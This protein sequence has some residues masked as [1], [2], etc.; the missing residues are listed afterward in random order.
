MWR[1]ILVESDPIGGHAS[2]AGETIR[3]QFEAGFM[4]FR[5]FRP[6]KEVSDAQGTRQTFE[7]YVTVTC[8]FH[9]VLDSLAS[10]AVTLSD[11]LNPHQLITSSG[12]FHELIIQVSSTFLTLSLGP[13]GHVSITHPAGA[14]D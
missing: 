2:H 13:P 3:V 12:I 5:P 9:A 6:F 4:R 14:T 7:T 1:S 10:P 8:S 11:M